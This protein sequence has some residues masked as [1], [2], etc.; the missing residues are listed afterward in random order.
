MERETIGHMKDGNQRGSSDPML[1]DGRACIDVVERHPG[2]RQAVIGVFVSREKIVGLDGV[3]GAR[4]TTAL[5]VMREG[6]EYAGYRVEGFV[7]TF[8]AAQKLGEAGIETKTLQAHLAQGQKVDTGEK[9]L[10]VVDESSLASTRQMHE[11]VSRLHPN[12]RVLL[13]GDT[14]QHESVEAGRIFAQVQESG[15]KTV[16]LEEIVRQKDPELK[17]TVE[18][19]ARGDVGLAVAGLAESMR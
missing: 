10:C 14:R 3:A 16:R 7:P 4:K 11:F 6:A 18:Q 15:M 9:R 13:V 2:Q 17:Q 19:L 12:G 8:R 5:A 1:V